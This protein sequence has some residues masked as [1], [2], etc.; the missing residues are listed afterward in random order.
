VNTR[1]DI[2]YRFN[3]EVAR[4]MDQRYI[5]NMPD[6]SAQLD[7]PLGKVQD[8]RRGKALSYELLIAFVKKYRKQEVS[9]EYLLEGRN[10]PKGQPN[11]DKARRFLHGDD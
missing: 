9:Y 4:L 6:L 3:Q 1:E 8:A 10:K 11:L 7:I 2:L 5:K